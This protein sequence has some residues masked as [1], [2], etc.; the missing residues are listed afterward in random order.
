VAKYL[1]DAV[2]RP[3]D[4]GRI[5]FA[6]HDGRNEVRLF[7]NIAS[8]GMGGVVDRIVNEGPKWLG[9]KTAVLLG[10]ARASLSYKNV[11]GRVTVDGEL[12]YEGPVFNVAVANGRAFGGGMFVAP[13]ADPHD[14]LFDV[15]V[16]GDLSRFETTTLPR[17]IYNGTHIGRRHVLHRRGHV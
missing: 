14:G 3:F 10:S 1:A 12:M 7:G 2:P 13:E 4:L 11:Q 8:F 9:G 16:L 5:S 6:R 15:V 17:Y